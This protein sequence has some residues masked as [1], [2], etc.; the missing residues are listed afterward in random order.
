MKLIFEVLAIML[1]ALFAGCSN[2]HKESNK[3]EINQ[4]LENP[5]S[6]LE[7]QIQIHGVVSQADSGKQLFSVISKKE[8]QECGI[9]ECN[10]ND[11]LPVRYNGD[12][13]EIGKQVVIIGMVKQAEKGYIYEAESLGNI[14]DLP[15]SQ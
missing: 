15:I 1:V 6:F 4:V 9:D 3:I 11:Q 12:L 7:K 5:A 8:F 2:A 14:K 10:A 13:P